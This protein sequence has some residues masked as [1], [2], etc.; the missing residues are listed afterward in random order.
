MM[1]LAEKLIRL[2][3]M[4][5]L[6]QLK[7]A[8]MMNVSRQAISRWEVG[9]AIPST[10]NLKYLSSLYG[11]SLEYLLN[12]EIQEPE[13]NAEASLEEN[14]GTSKPKICSRK[15]MIIVAAVVLSVILI[16]AIS[17]GCLTAQRKNKISMDN[18]EGRVVETFRSDFSVAW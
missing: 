10:E 1:N 11:V 5:G 8:E 7:L 3:K 6:T 2:R 15:S 12:D 14:S 18:M 17:I 4:K 16:A 9:D 13:R